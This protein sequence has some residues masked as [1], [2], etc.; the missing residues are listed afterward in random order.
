MPNQC[1]NDGITNFGHKF[2][3][4][5]QSKGIDM[6]DI[7]EI[8]GQSK[9]SIRNYRRVVKPRPKTLKK[10]ALSLKIDVS[11]LQKCNSVMGSQND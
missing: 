1:L 6:S 4:I 11:E 2:D 10:L 8:L 7:A 9:Q 3:A 5:R